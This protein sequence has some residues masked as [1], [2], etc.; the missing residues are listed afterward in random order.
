MLSKFQISNIDQQDGEEDI[1][2]EINHENSILESDH[3][4]NNSYLQKDFNEMDKSA[5][6]TSE[7]VAENGDG[8]ENDVEADQDSPN[9]NPV[10]TS[11]TATNNNCDK[12]AAQPYH[13]GTDNLN[14][15][16]KLFIV[17]RFI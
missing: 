2:E 17:R 14:G 15:K 11:F 16:I 1:P 10:N 6:N 7:N 12:T 13:P 8:T 9:G 4:E 3:D 5:E